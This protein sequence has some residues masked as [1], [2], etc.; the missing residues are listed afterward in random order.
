MEMTYIYD[1]YYCVVKIA[2]SPCIP[3]F[4]H[5]LEFLMSAVMSLGI[6]DSMFTRIYVESGDSN[7][8]SDCGI[9][10]GEDSLGAQGPGDIGNSP[11]LCHTYKCHITAANTTIPLLHTTHHPPGVA[12]ITCQL[13]WS[14]RKLQLVAIVR[15][16]QITIFSQ[17]R[18][19]TFATRCILNS[20]SSAH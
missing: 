19:L 10:S 8:D 16:H 7:I 18:R 11:V 12:S 13:P 6:I 2:S 3:D 14:T 17:A 20:P 15:Y 1:T 9:K 4:E 5:S